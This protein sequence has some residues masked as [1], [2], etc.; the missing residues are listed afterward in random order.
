M[1][2]A[3]IGAAIGRTK[4]TVIGK[5]RRMGLPPRVAR[6][7]GDSLKRNGDQFRTLWRRGVAMMEI[8][9]TM[10]MSRS[11]A[12]KM[13]R[14]LGLPARAQALGVEN[15]RPTAKREAEKSPAAA[16]LSVPMASVQP[17]SFAAAAARGC[18][19]LGGSPGAR[20]RMDIREWAAVYVLWGASDGGAVLRGSCLAS[21]RAVSG[22]GE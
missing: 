7:T 22:G 13:R 6:K 21:I 14:D 4:G 20:V 2:A 3:E 1:S 16:P 19:G 5:A 10:Q 12:Q 9:E 11:S 18:C 15:R 8:C 17:P